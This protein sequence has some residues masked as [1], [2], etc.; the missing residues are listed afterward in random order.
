MQ[1]P[2]HAVVLMLRIYDKFPTLPL[3]DDDARRE[4]IRKCGEQIVHIFGPR[5]GNKKRAGVG[6]EF[7]SKDA[8]AY[9]EDDG[10]CSVWDTQNGSSRKL[11]VMPGSAPHYPR[12]PTDVATFMPLSPVNHLGI[13]PV[14]RPL[15]SPPVLEDRTLQTRVFALEGRVESLLQ[16]IK[17][18]SD[19][20]LAIHVSTVQKPLKDHLPRYVAKIRLF[21]FMT[22]IVSTPE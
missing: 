1:F 14:D 19:F 3:G 21:G 22:T 15:P 7:R 2:S 13:D 11:S 10:T 16:R 4:L 12:L 8:I 5:W 20:A 6:D 9:L 17:E 18:V